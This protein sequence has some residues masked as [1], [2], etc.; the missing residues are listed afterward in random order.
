[1]TARILQF[2]RTVA[3]SR[4]PNLLVVEDAF[5]TKVEAEADQRFWVR[6]EKDESDTVVVSDFNRGSLAEEDL[7]RALQLAVAAAG[8]ADRSKIV[9]K[10][11]VSAAALGAQFGFKLERST[12]MVKR[13]CN[14]LAL[15]NRRKLASFRI[16][17]RGRKMDAQASF[18]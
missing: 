16:T 8:A 14:A 1:M 13:A 2:P 4:R 15:A 3:Q 7:I 10:D 18:S 11:L 6:V 12:E 5:S 9:F 17:P